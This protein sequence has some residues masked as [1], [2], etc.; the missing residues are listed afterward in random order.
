MMYLLGLLLLASYVHA[1]VKFRDALNSSEC[2]NW[3][4]GGECA[5]NLKFMWTNCAGSCNFAD[6][7]S[8]P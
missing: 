4:L 7:N 3:A 2:R 8:R 1:A 5:K 6:P